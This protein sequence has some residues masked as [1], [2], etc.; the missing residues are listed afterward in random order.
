MLRRHFSGGGALTD[1]Q[2]P[3][4]PGALEAP[5]P[6]PTAVDCLVSWNGPDGRITSAGPLCRERA[7]QLVRAYRRLYPDEPCWIQPVPREVENLHLGR[8]RRP[9][10]ST[11]RGH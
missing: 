10:T 6:D 4:E 7:E 3:A 5:G 9:R 1:K 2:A 8:V 11:D